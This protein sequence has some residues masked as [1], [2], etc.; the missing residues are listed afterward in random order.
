MPPGL[1][2]LRTQLPL[3]RLERRLR[4]LE[5]QA[6]VRLPP[7]VPPH[8]VVDVPEDRTSVGPP[9][10]EGRL[11]RPDP[12]LDLP[13]RL[14]VLHPPVDGGAPGPV[15][16]WRGTPLVPPARTNVSHAN[17]AVGRL[18]IPY[19]TT[20]RE[21]SSRI[22]SR[23]GPGRRTVESICPREFANRRSN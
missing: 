5:V 21:A 20:S 17:A 11:D 14:R 8:D 2:F 18:V 16:G 1:P 13:A 9:P 22:T 15:G 4:V 19:P 12:P 6:H 7:V 23:W 3:E 10:P